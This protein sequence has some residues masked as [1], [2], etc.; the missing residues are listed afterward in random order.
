MKTLN[1]IKEMVVMNDEQGQGGLVLGIIFGTILI[2][3]VAIP[4]T[5]QTIDDSN[6][7]G[8][9]ATITGFIPVFLAVGGLSLAASVAR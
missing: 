9:T 6:L 2:V 8:L 5:Q 1:T 7:T 4:V 3:G